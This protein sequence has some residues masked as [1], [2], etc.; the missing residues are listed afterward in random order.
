[1]CTNNPDTIRTLEH[2]LVNRTYTPWIDQIFIHQKII[3]KLSETIGFKL[4]Y[5]TIDKTIVNNKY[6]DIINDQRYL[7]TEDL[8]KDQGYIDLLWNN[9]ARTIADETNGKILDGHFGLS[10]HNV[11]TKL[12][13]EDIIKKI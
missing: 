4:F 3:N 6:N 12:F 7:I 9:G 13:Y 8:N 11:I 1:L 5:W 2:I 10:G